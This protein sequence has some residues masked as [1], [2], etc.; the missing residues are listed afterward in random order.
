MPKL[1][2]PVSLALPHLPEALE[3][4][5]I[6]HLTDLH[7]RRLRARH[8][9]LIDAL[10]QVGADL[11]VLT[12]DF[13]DD[14]GDEPITHDLLLRIVKACPPRVASVGVFG[15]HD[16]ADLFRRVDYLPVRWLHN[17]AWRCEQLP[18]TVLGVSCAGNRCAGDLLKALLAEPQVDKDDE[19]RLRM[20]LAHMPGWLTGAADAGIDLVLS[21]HTHGGQIRLP[22][23]RF[24]YNGIDHWPL[25]LTSGVIRRGKTFGVVSR[26]VGEAYMDRLR[27]L[28]P[29]HVP[30]ITLR[31]ATGLMDV[32]DRTVNVRRW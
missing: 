26:G 21:G 9:E 5:S 1:I 25:R 32:P 24:L 12:G 8:H 23:R 18:L 2:D 13:M 4:L 10:G 11:L 14:L 28:C 6:L 30:L 31:K 16:S 17:D 20:L 7:V 27:I 3:G 19:P 22:W 29:P 15:N